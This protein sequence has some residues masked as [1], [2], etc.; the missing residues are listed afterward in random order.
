MGPK[1]DLKLGSRKNLFPLLGVFV[2]LCV[3]FVGFYV[4]LLLFF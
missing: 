4:I 2:V 3:R 1:P